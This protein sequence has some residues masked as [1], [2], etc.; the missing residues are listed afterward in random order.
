MQYAQCVKEKL[1]E[2]GYDDI[3]LR[4]DIWRSMNSRFNQ[5]QIDPRLDLLSSGA[6]WSPWKDTPWL[7]PLLTNLSDWRTRMQQ[8]ES[9]L[10][11]QNQDVL[12]TF[13]ADF[14]GNHR[15][16]SS[17]SIRKH[18][19]PRFTFGELHPTGFKYNN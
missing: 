4:F 19:C 2:H 17:F 8:I 9:Q 6:T 3:E 10:A 12:V 14:P 15:H 7:Q 18:F 11:S 1:L 13:V 16:F 5:R